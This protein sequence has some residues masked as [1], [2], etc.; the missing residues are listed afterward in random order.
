MSG[1]FGGGSP[2]PA[3]AGPTSGT[4]TT[5]TREAPEIEAR[6]LALYDE[7]LNLSKQPIEIPAYQVNQTTMKKI[8]T[9][10]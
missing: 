10:M 7:A 1:L 3:P 5:F 2:A 4:T 6:K 9:I 8:T